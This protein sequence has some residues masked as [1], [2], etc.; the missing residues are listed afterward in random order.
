MAGTLQAAIRIH[1]VNESISFIVLAV[2]AQGLHGYVT[3]RSSPPWLANTMPAVL[4]QCTSP[5]AVAQPG[6]TLD[7]AVLA[8]PALAAFTLA[9][10]T[11]PVFRTARVTSSLITRWAGPAFLTAAGA[12]HANTVRAAVHRT[13]LIGA[14]WASPIWVTSAGAAFLKVCPMARALVGAHG[15]Q[16]FTVTATPSWVAVTFSMDTHPMI[17]TSRVQTVRFFTI[18]SFVPRVASARAHDAN[19]T[20]PTLRVNAL[21]S[22][23]I[24]L[25]AL[26]ATETQ[27]A[28]LGVLPIA[29]TEHRTSCS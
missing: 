24:T 14:V 1:A 5:I 22:R 29:T 6:A 4:V 23:H 8:V 18:F 10:L 20:T 11:G 26:P 2:C 25:G 17:G 7:G 21:G 12:P 9:V 16:Y 15:L 19:P 13:Y 28:A 27:A 3:A